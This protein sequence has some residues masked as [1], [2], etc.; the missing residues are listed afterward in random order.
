MVHLHAG[1]AEP[2]TRKIGGETA[3]LFIADAAV[4]KHLVIAAI[5]DAPS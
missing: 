1:V 2:S 4:F 5:A 3:E